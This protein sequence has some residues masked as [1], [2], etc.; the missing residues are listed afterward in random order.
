MK[1][2]KPIDELTPSDLAKFPIWEFATGDEEAGDETYV[3]PVKAKS[4]PDDDPY[5]VYQVACD[6]ITRSGASF[7]GF[8]IVSESAV[9]EGAIAVVGESGK[10][11]WLLDTPP[12]REEK[13][14]FEAFFGCSYKNVFP[15]KWTLR[16]LVASEAAPISGTFQL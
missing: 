1:I 6:V 13:A 14:S 2:L 3:R 12:T 11:Y 10:D 4:V 9:E 7:T 5:Q 15:A 16:V 8:A